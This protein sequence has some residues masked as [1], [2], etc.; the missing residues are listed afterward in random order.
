[1]DFMRSH[2]PVEGHPLGKFLTSRFEQPHRLQR[3]IFGLTR[4]APAGHMSN[5]VGPGGNGPALRID[6]RTSLNS[7]K[8]TARISYYSEPY[9]LSDSVASCGTEQ[10]S[11]MET[12]VSR[13]LRRPLRRFV[14]ESILSPDPTATQPPHLALLNY[15]HRLITLN[16]SSR[17]LEFAKPLLGVHAPFDRPMVLLDDV[18]QILDGS[19][20]APAGER[21]FLLYICDGRAV[22]RSQIR[23]D[24][25]G[26]RMR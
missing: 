8:S 17:S 10:E 25:T 6:L 7:G 4:S 21:P 24:D 5:L 2:R 19:V 14:D 3:G 20:T 9:T 13:K 11:A 1:L 12:S 22:D 16:R 23:V 26:L 15:I 18:V